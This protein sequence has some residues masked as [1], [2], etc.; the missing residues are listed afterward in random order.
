MLIRLKCG[1]W[2]CI[3]TGKFTRTYDSVSA[4]LVDRDTACLCFRLSFQGCLHNKQ[5]WGKNQK[6]LKQQTYLFIGICYCYWHVSNC[7]YKSPHLS[8]SFIILHPFSRFCGR[9]HSLAFY[10]G[11]LMALLPIFKA[12]NSNTSLM[13]KALPLTVTPIFLLLL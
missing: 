2:S 11:Y 12:S 3:P 5:P 4:S 6:C 13:H 7:C 10:R 8:G 1:Q 9:I